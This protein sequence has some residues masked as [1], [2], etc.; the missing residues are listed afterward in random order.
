MASG[1]RISVAEEGRRVPVTVLKLVGSLDA[2][3]AMQLEGKALEAQARGAKDLLVDLGGVTYIGSAGIRAIHDIYREYH[4][5][6]PEDPGAVPT[7]RSPHMKLLRPSPAVQ[8]V[9]QTLG[10]DMVYDVYQ[11]REAALSAF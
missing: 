6:K 3:T 1:L 4:L 2:V 5:D 8:R 11:D 9:F 10:F 7:A